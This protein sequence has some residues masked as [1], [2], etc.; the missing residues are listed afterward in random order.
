MAAYARHALG[1][2]HVAVVAAAD[3][4]VGDGD[5]HFSMMH[6]AFRVRAADLGLVVA[7]DSLLLPRAAF[8]DQGAAYGAASA[9]ALPL[10]LAPDAL[11]WL[12]AVPQRAFAVFMPAAFV[13]RFML[14]VKAVREG[15]LLNAVWMF[16]SRAWQPLTERARA[17]YEM[18]TATAGAIY[19]DQCSGAEYAPGSSDAPLR[20]A[21][22]LA[23]LPAAAAAEGIVLPSTG[24]SA[25]PLTAMLA[26]V[27][28]YDATVAAA[29]LARLG[30]GRSVDARPVRRQRACGVFVGVVLWKL[31]A[32]RANAK[33]EHV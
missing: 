16:P 26:V 14:A 7:R 10:A 22:I 23:R 28:T 18:R 9:S 33:G 3:D 20:L 17:P 15:A 12:R 24:A 27:S 13:G 31:R 1:L 5:S 19:A 30:T 6:Q 2:V 32:Q 4:V 8:V 25:L 21:S 29:A 11:Q